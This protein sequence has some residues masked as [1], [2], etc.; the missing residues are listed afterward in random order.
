M[1]RHTYRFQQLGV[2]RCIEGAPMFHKPWPGVK[3]ARVHN[4]KLLR[5]QVGTESSKREDCIQRG[6]W[7]Q[8]PGRIVYKTFPK[9]NSA[10]RILW[11]YNDCYND[12]FSEISGERGGCGKADKRSF[13]RGT[14]SAPWPLDRCPAP[15]RIRRSLRDGAAHGGRL[16]H[17]HEECRQRKRTPMDVRASD[18]TRSCSG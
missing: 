7:G 16:R 8:P 5:R 2:Y 4:P 10:A 6:G 12:G 18:V 3:Q 14:L 13:F 17:R 9:A 11:L 15:S 1:H